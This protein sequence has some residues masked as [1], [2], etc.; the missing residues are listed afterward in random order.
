MKYYRLH[1]D[2]KNKSI[3]DKITKVLGV[4]PNEDEGEKKNNDFYSLWTY[5][6]D[7][8][9]EGPCYDFI[10]NF[11]D[12]IEPKLPELEEIGVLKEDISF[13][14]IYEYDKQC[15][16]EFNSAEMKRL[17]ESGIVLCIDCF[18][19]TTTKME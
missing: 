9:D 6:F 18:E 12:I 2:C 3:Y 17:G 1:I 4:A 13:W 7:E 19:K 10:N 15:G 11:L 5:A 16:M 14:M 8:K